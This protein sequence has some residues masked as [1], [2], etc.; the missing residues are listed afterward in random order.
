MVKN[1]HFFCLCYKRLKRQTY[2]ERL[3][4]LDCGIAGFTPLTY[5]LNTPTILL[6]TGPF[7]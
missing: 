3:L 6:Q 7:P 4:L 5:S 1:L 2:C